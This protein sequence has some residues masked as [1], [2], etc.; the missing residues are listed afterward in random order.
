MEDY[1]KELYRL[2][3]TQLGY[4]ILAITSA[5]DRK[6]CIIRIQGGEPIFWCLVRRQGA[7]RNFWKFFKVLAGTMGESINRTEL[8]KATRL[9]ST[10]IFSYPP[11]MPENDWK[12]YQIS[13]KQFMTQASE[14]GW[15]RNQYGGELT[16]CIPFDMLE[17]IPSPH[18]R[19]STLE[20]KD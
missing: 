10:L 15:I 6:H 8:Y 12:H 13:A 16:Y 14:N 5:N 4:S 9:D 1:R 18:L 7:F 3:D 19:Q 20:P 11:D 17:F 2:I